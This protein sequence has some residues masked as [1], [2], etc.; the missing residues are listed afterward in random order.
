MGEPGKLLPICHRTCGVS[1]RVAAV[2]RDHQPLRL[3]LSQRIRKLHCL[4]SLETRGLE[5]LWQGPW[6]GTAGREIKEIRTECMCVWPVWCIWQ[7]QTWDGD[8]PPPGKM[9]TPFGI[10]C[11]P[12]QPGLV[13]MQMPSW[14]RSLHKGRLTL[15]KNKDWQLWAKEARALPPDSPP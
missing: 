6:K 4:I 8:A 11:S 5:V 7:G 1:Y 14:G 12:S 13:C 15:T 2:C 3:F 10:P 9:R